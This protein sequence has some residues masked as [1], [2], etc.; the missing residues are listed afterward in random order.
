MGIEE[1]SKLTVARYY[2]IGFRRPD[3]PNLELYSYYS[4]GGFTAFRD[5]GL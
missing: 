5:I 4:F 2:R 3:L 1:T